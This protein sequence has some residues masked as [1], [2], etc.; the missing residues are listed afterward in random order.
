[1]TFP[2]VYERAIR[3]T[4]GPQPGALA[5][6]DW[7]VANYPDLKSLGIYVNRPVRGGRTLSTHAEGRAIDIGTHKPTFDRITGDGL[8]ERLWDSH[9]ELGIQCVIWWERI[10][11]NT[12]S[13][14]GWRPYRGVSPHR[15]HLHIELTRAA[16]KAL[17]PETINRVLGGG[18]VPTTTT[19]RTGQIKEWQRRLAEAGYASAWWDHADGVTPMVDPGDTAAVDRYADDDFGRWTLADSLD[20]LADLNEAEFDPDT[21][22]KAGL[23]DD[24]IATFHKVNTEATR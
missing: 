3:P 14:E 9:V 23:F 16:A 13:L 15:D 1:M 24:I 5:L 2:V 11:T 20:L 19:D 22:R 21:V 8:A 6:K 18:P 7:I 4:N 17:T 12:R 10:R